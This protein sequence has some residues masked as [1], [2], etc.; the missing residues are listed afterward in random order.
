MSKMGTEV[1]EQGRV[2]RVPV[3]RMGT[4][5]EQGHVGR[6]PACVLGSIWLNRLVC[7]PWCPDKI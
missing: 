6:V 5:G 7:A 1:E 2:R 3:S 4:G